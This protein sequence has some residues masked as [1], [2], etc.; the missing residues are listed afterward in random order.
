MSEA[1]IST[2]IYLFYEYVFGQW[3]ATIWIKKISG[4]PLARKAQRACP[5][6]YVGPALAGPPRAGKRTER[7]TST[8][9]KSWKKSKLKLE[10]PGEGSFGNSLSRRTG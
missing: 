10:D 6:K 1:Q 9:R 7:K 8:K 5:G 4:Q 3:G 2:F